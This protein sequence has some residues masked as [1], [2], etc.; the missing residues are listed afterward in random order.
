M[1]HKES[2]IAIGFRCWYMFNTNSLR[3]SYP[4]KK[5]SSV[6]QYTPL[7]NPTDI[8]AKAI[9]YLSPSTK[10]KFIEDIQSNKQQSID[11]FIKI[12]TKK[13]AHIGKL[14]TKQ[15]VSKI[16]SCRKSIEKA[17][18]T[19]KTENCDKIKAIAIQELSSLP[20]ASIKKIKINNRKYGSM[21]QLQKLQNLNKYF[22]ELLDFLQ[23]E[24]IDDTSQQSQ[25]ILEET[26]TFKPY[27]L[28]TF[29]PYSVF[30]FFLC[31]FFLL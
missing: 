17:I 23:D 29:K 8:Y 13:R 14:L 31:F 28:L 5:K 22:D 9:K 6:Q 25:T 21:I 3:F 27:S 19:K 24:M 10:I 16:K 12:A 7:N 11:D 18:N 26:R 20:L 1:A 15:T 4:S 30:N 2:S